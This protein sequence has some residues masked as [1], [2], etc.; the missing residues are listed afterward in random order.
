MAV[1]KKIDAPFTQVANELIEELEIDVLGAWIKMVK[2]PADWNFS[3]ETVMELFGCSKDKLQRICKT[4]KAVGV[5]EIKPARSADGKTLDGYVWTVAAMPVFIGSDQDALFSASLITSQPENQAAFKRKNLTNKDS[6]TKKRAEK[7]PEDFTLD[8]SL[9]SWMNDNTPEI[10][11]VAAL[12][13]FKKYWKADGGLKKDWRATFRKAMVRY[14]DWNICIKG[15]QESQDLK[16]DKGDRHDIK[17][18]TGA[19]RDSKKQH[20]EN[21]STTPSRGLRA[22][23]AKTKTNDASGESRGDAGDGGKDQSNS[24]SRFGANPVIIASV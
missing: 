2:K 21:H 7:L 24:S 8:D 10:D 20:S 14:I 18:G 9:I 4:L 19:A 15:S 5:L 22:G 13:H 1:L 17:K 6:L 11:Q 12:I 16:N 23:A 3:Q